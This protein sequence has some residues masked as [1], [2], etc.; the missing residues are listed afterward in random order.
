MIGI[1]VALMHGGATDP[2]AMSHLAGFLT[3]AERRCA[4]H[5]LIEALAAQALAQQDRGIVDAAID[6]LARA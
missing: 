4:A 1:R 6:S 3:S 2:D 5:T